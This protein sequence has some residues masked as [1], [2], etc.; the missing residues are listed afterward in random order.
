[1][2]FLSGRQGLSAD[3]K[4]RSHTRCVL[5]IDHQNSGENANFSNT[6]AYMGKVTGIQRK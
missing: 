5:G 1:M 4:L 3:R 6:P 2:G